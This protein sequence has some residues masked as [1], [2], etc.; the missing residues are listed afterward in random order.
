MCFDLTGE[1]FIQNFNILN[2]F[3]PASVVQLMS[4]LLQRF[5]PKPI[6]LNVVSLSLLSMVTNRYESAPDEKG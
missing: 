6:S 1:T 3:K 2:I 5:Y 4:V